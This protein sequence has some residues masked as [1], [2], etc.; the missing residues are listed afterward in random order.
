MELNHF[1]SLP[2][3]LA[4]ILSE[5]TK[6]GR[7]LKVQTNSGICGKGE[8]VRHCKQFILTGAQRKDRREVHR[9]FCAL[10]RGLDFILRMIGSN[11]EFE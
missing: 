10:L 1:I 3:P 11:E 7:D 8:W 2:W 5:V 4:F 9:A 6:H